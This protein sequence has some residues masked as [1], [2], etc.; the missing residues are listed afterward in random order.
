MNPHLTRRLFLIRSA[1]FATTL[2]AAPKFQKYPFS[3]GTMSGDPT[4]DG[5]VLWT[6]LAPD[7]VNGGGMDNAAVEVEWQVAE[8]ESMRKVVRRGKATA[9]PLLAHSV[10]VEIG[11]LK[12]ARPYWYRFK[13]GGEVSRVARAM[14]APK[15]GEPHSRLKFAFASCQHW[16]AGYWTA[17]K[18]MLAENPDLVVHLGDYIYEGRVGANG[19]RKHNGD[20]IKSL[21][22]YRN[23]HALYKT[24]PHLQA[25]H[26]HCP[27]I[28]TWDDHEV[29]NNYAGDIPEDKQTRTDFLERRA[30]AYQAYY[31]HMPLRMPAKPE[32]SKMQLYRRVSFGDLAEFS[33]LD[34]RQYRT[35]QPC[36]DG[37]K[38]PCDGTYDPKGTILGALQE[39]WLKDSLDQSHAK[40]NIIA[41]QVLM[42]R[43]DLK[44]GPEEV[45]SMD[46]WSGYE[47]CRN[48][49]LE[50][51]R[52]RKPSNPIVITGDIHSNW[53]TDLKVDWKDEKSPVVASEFVGT[54][55]T[56]GGDGSEERPTT[57]DWYRENPHLKMY[58]SRR[59][60]VTLTLDAVQCRADYRV[61]DYVT[62]PDAPVRAHSS[63]VVESGRTGVRKL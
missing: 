34:T 61:M 20:E 37:S 38:P 31:E 43:I 28:V 41:N 45:V 40:W 2:Y 42:A 9:S 48:R 7:P 54:S 59:G 14:T 4:S 30:N 25:M 3:L 32:G 29:D 51:L 56:S 33:V 12:S 44:P 39:A 13:A 5:F 26:Q 15:P 17:Y 22:D 16:E 50:F 58:N 53:V 57:Q 8:D 11:G 55:I 1:A 46:Q 19:V 47:V 62:R 18:H 52:D 49:F 36:G 27:W 60:Y 35:D 21:A 23:R 63:W 6:R 10:H 24:D